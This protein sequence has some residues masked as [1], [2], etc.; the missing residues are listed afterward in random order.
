MRGRE[1]EREREREEE[2]PLVTLGCMHAFR[3][4]MEMSV[5]ESRPSRADCGSCCCGKGAASLEQRVRE[6][7]AEGRQSTRQQGAVIREREGWYRLNGKT[8]NAF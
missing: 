3:S 5:R 2:R 7:E 1:R 8:L 4:V 6:S